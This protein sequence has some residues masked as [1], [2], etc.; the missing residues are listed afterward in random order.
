MNYFLYLAKFI[1]HKLKLLRLINVFIILGLA[2]CT[3][4]TI[5]QI[6]VVKPGDT[7]YSIARQHR[8]ELRQLVKLNNINSTYRLH[9]GQK[10]LINKDVVKKNKAPNNKLIH[11]N[12][13]RQ[14]IFNPAIIHGNQKLPMLKNSDVGGDSHKPKIVKSITAC[15]HNSQK[16][17]KATSTTSVIVSKPGDHPTATSATANMGKNFPKINW[18]WPASGKIIKSFTIDPRVKFN[19]ID[20]AGRHGDQILSASNGKVVYVGNSLRGYGNLIIIKHDQDFLSAY[21]HNH[22][23]L[24]KE[25][26]IV[27]KGQQIATM[28]NTD[29]KIVKLH[30]QVRFKGKPVDP[31]KFLPKL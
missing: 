9:P 8:T 30:F 25:Q 26:Q 27:V 12:S 5:Q 20:I 29:A 28:G 17:F 15:G 4:K 11:F 31:L 7:V 3:H 14:K 1:F 23:I 10:L 18:S 6:Y 13:H 22:K 19:G 2:G 24:V 21:A 16:L